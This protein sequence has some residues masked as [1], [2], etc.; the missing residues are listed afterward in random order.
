MIW[1]G[2]ITPEKAFKSLQM[3]LRDK[4]ADVRGLHYWWDP[5]LSKK[6]LPRFPHFMPPCHWLSFIIID[7]LSLIIIDDYW[8]SL[9][10]I[11]DYWSS[12]IA[13]DC[14]WLSLIIIDYQGAHHP[15]RPELFFATRTRPKLFFKISHFRVFPSKLYPNRLIQIF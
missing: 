9:I 2:N 15:T 13:I 7:W 3:Q 8:S 10:I 12:L 6:P 1:H 11:D 5:S 14:H 4:T